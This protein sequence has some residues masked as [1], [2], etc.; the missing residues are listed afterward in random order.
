MGRTAKHRA[1]HVWFRRDRRRLTALFVA[2]ALLVSPLA[3]LGMADAHTAAMNG[4]D[5]AAT[6]HCPPPDDQMDRDRSDR[7]ADCLKACAALAVEVPVFQLQLGSV[8]E[9]PR[10]SLAASPRAQTRDADPP[11]PRNA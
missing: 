9:A 8:V 6:E 5:M 2:L 10:P 7:T 4:M 1:R 11:P 3:M